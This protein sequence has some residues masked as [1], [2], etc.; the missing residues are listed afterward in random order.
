M[1]RSKE[2]FG[3]LY[4]LS[5]YANNANDVN[6]QQAIAKAE[7]VAIQEILNIK[8]EGNNLDSQQAWRRSFSVFKTNR[9][10]DRQDDSNANG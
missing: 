1:K 5:A 9:Q 3:A 10:D 2:I 4:E 8:L 6:L 7:N